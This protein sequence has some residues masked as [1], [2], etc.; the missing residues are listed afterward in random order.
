MAGPA[1]GPLF[2]LVPA[3]RLSHVQMWALDHREGRALKNWCFLILVLEKTLESPLDS[4]MIKLIN[5]SNGKVNLK[6]NEAWIFTRRTDAEAEAPVLWQPDVKRPW[7]WE[8]LKS[9]GEKG[10][11]G[12]DGWMASPIQWTWTWANSRYWWWTGKPGRLQ[13]MGSQRVGLN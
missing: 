10:D 9:E 12:W 13:S 6:G 4:K 1:L 11:R 8:R 3:Y 7:G 5:W 2:F